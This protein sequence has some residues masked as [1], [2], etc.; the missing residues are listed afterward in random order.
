[1]TR[2]AIYAR[3]SSDLQDDRSIEDQ[4]ALCHTITTRAGYEIVA[5]FEDRAI[6]GRATENRPGF[7]AMLQAAVAGKF[8]VIVVEHID[9]LTRDEGDW[10]TLKRQLDYAGVKIHTASG[11]VGRVEGSVVAMVAA[12]QSEATGIHTH[13]GM[14]GAI[15]K[16]RSVGGKA[17]GYKPVKGEPG[18]LSIVPEEAAVIRRVF[19]EYLAGDSPRTIAGALNRDRIPPPRGTHWNASTIMGSR[20]RGHGILLNAIYAGKIV[21]NRVRM[22]KHPDTRKRLSRVNP[23]SDWLTAAAPQ[24]RIIDPETF[25]AVQK[26]RIDHSKSYPRMTHKPRHMLSGIL[27]CG[28]CEAGMS[29][30]SRDRKGRRIYCTRF[31]ES[32]TCENSR[33]YYLD[34]I[35]RAVVSGLRETLGS[36]AAI[37]HY[38]RAFND[39]RRRT[40]SEAINRRGRIER[41]IAEAQRALDRMIDAHIHERVTDAEAVVRLPLLRDDRDRLARELAATDAPPKLIALHPAAVTTYLADL[42]RLA[43]LIAGDLAQGDSELATALRKLVE[44]VT[45]R[46]APAGTPPTIHVQGRLETLLNRQAFTDGSVSRG[47]VVAGTGLG[48][49]PTTEMPGFSFTRRVG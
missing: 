5:T 20:K 9:R 29:V 19:T 46:Q 21:W 43:D 24:L 39:E 36:R 40:S 1:M 44:R 41:E 6:S 15:A 7:K 16:G 22:V 47:V 8:N 18:L 31:T 12:M 26:R 2:A 28:V 37:A 11:I 10:Q 49:N 32:G 27:R 14:T 17:Y 3:Y 42:D 25:D 35:E 38:I 4:V 33:G 34:D 45:V 13:R 30:R 48:R 23:E